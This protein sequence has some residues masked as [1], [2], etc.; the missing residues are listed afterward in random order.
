LCRYL[1]EHV[2][3][4]A[5]DLYWKHFERL[6]GELGYADYLGALQR[7]REEHPH[8]M[9]LLHVSRFM[10]SYPFTRTLFPRAL[11]S[12]SHVQQ[13]GLPVIL[14][15][16]DVVFQPVKIDRAGLCTVFDDRILIYIHKENELRDI[17]RHY[18]AQHYVLLDDKLCILAAV[19][20]S[21]GA[22]VT[23]VHLRQGHYNHEPYLPIRRLTHPRPNRTLVGLYAG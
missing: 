5:A 8:D 10:I 2:G 6:G 21:W 9:R 15:D 3:Q 22:R 12:V 16:G 13:W 1:I 20:K 23:T 4:D 7:S 17:E 11:E 19:K 14:S 18:P